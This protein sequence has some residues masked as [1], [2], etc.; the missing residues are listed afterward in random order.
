L[1][2]GWCV[3]AA[4]LA[5]T[6]TTTEPRR[7]AS[8]RVVSVGGGVLAACGEDEREE[9]VDADL[10]DEG[11]LAVSDRHLLALFPQRDGEDEQ[12]RAEVQQRQASPGRLRR[13][14]GGQDHH[15]G[16]PGH[17]VL[18]R[19]LAPVVRH[20]RRRVGS[21]GQP[22]DLE[23]LVCRFQ[24]VAKE[25]V[26][27]R[28]GGED[29]PD[30]VCA[31]RLNRAP[32]NLTLADL[33]LRS[34]ARTGRAPYR[35]REFKGR[36]RVATPESSRPADAPLMSCRFTRNADTNSPPKDGSDGRGSRPVSE[37]SRRI[38]PA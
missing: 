19:L 17:D 28:T 35:K 9:V 15:L 23:P 16:V 11:G 6:R 33:G 29:D 25:L 20:R 22:A 10:L 7:Q 1:T 31:G 24:E 12:V 38:G 5:W 14:G 32:R 2:E 34:A 36:Q 18:V 3:G 8:S 26:A 27:E 4:A 21:L 37:T 30:R 13:V